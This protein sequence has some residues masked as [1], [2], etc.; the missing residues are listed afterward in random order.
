[1]PTAGSSICTYPG[2]NTLVVKGRCSKHPYTKSPG[3]RRR[4]YPVNWQEVRAEKLRTDPHCEIRAYC[5]GAPA[6][7]VDHADNDRMNIHWSNLRSA[8]K[9]C[10][11]YKTATQDM[12]R[13]DSGRFSGPRR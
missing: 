12:S 6:V 8:C 3:N 10:H 13:D 1:M 2:C 11:S 7:E 9:R 5:R 4:R